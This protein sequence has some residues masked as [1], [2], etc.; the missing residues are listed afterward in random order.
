MNEQESI[1]FEEYLSK[2][3]SKEKCI[4]FENRL[5]NDSKFKTTFNTYKEL[6]S[7]LEH[8]FANE[9]K[10]QIF[11][12]NLNEISTN[13]F[14]KL[15]SKIKVVKFKSWQY[16]VAASFV[17]FLGTYTY[18]M[19]STPSFGD[20]S[21]YETISLSFRGTQNELLN[22]AESAFNNKNFANAITY[23]NQLLKINPNNQELQLYKAISEVEVNKFDEADSL[24]I[25][26]SQ[27]NSVYKNKALWHL[28]LSK[29]KQKDIKSCVEILK[30]IPE[31]ADDYTNSQKLLD[32][33][34]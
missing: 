28:A 12:K 9:D 34:Q 5:Q 2:T 11:K 6:S 19:L 14:E 24:L 16:A 1:L 30:N 15:K 33:L 18:N 3:L 22:N 31:D 20:Y 13:H 10:S 26:I 27:G 8:K 23:F 25:K 17:I 7:F 21:N 32:K 29:F 4:T